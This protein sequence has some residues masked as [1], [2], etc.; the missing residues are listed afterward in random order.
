MGKKG[1]HYSK[2]SPK[3]KA[4]I[5]RQAAK[6]DVAATVRLYAKKLPN[7]WAM[8]MANLQF[9]VGRASMAWRSAKIKS[10]KV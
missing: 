7:C 2:L 6:Q 9:E 1:Q 8:G 4:E 5:G 10:G 3:M